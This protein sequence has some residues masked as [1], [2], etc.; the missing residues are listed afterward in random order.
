MP[1]KNVFICLIILSNNLSNNLCNI[2]FGSET[3]LF[4]QTVCFIG[5]VVS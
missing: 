1:L 2:E 4:I 5:F 3:D